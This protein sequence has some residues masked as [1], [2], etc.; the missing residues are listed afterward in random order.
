[1]LSDAEETIEIPIMK[2]PD[3]LVIL[4]ALQHRAANAKTRN[5]K[6]HCVTEC[7]CTLTTSTLIDYAAPEASSTKHM[8]GTLEDHH[9]IIR[10]THL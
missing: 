9:S 1:V 2:R 10:S 7:H 3:V 8:A 4:A 5:I 6:K